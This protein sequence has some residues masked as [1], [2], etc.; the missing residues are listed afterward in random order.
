MTTAVVVGSGPNGLAAA[1]VL[2]RAGVEVTVFEAHQEIGGGA[3]TIHSPLPGLVQD[4]CAA[5]HPMAAGSEYMAS[6]ELEKRG[7][8]WLRAP[9]DAAHPLDDGSIAVLHQSIDK[10]AAGLGADGGRWR[11]MFGSAA[12][13]F[14]ALSEDIFQPMLRI[15]RHP[16]L[17]GRFG[18][19]AGPP[20]T[21][22]RHLLRTPQGRALFTGVAAHAINRIDRPLVGGIGAGIIAAGHAV[23]WPVVE[24]G[25]GRLTEAIVIGL[26]D[27]GVRFETSTPI[28]RRSDLP[29]H[30]IAML[31]LHPRNVVPLY[32]D[33]LPRRVRDALARFRSGPAAFKVDL[34]V[35][36]GIPWRN[37]EA[38][39]AGTVHLGGS[40][41][42]IAWT[43]REIALGR[44]P[45][46][47][48]VLVGQQ[49]VADPTRADGEIKPVY[50]YAHVPAG[51]DADAT[52]AVLAQLERFA[53]GVRERVVASVTQ[54]PR[55]L[56]RTNANFIGGDILTG[57]KSPLQ[58]LFGPRLTP[59]PYDL[60][61]TGVYLCSAA[62]S[63]GPGIHGQSG[64]NAAQ[65]AL[66]WID[67]RVGRT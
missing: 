39:S 66:R 62:T 28:R 17:L 20:P 33:L 43:E 24:G 9:I 1:T 49:Y 42:E 38:G 21:W 60:G 58:F 41:E 18:I 56:A 27:L 19:V 26:K 36:G 52:G 6:W 16:F 10:T 61:V 40:S 30:D 50:A 63:P 12:R 67:R 48:F 34:A 57:A 25:T 29:R 22:T 47:P 45:E 37:P 5:V 13:N 31:D 11:A 2:A 23:G 51:Y 14:P 8:R 65:R 44:M 35:E 64:V 53:P 7:V 55:D 3:R 32:G 4:H 54:S 46:R 59:H 15:P